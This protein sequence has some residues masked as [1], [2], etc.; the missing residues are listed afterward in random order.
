MQRLLPM[1]STSRT[2]QLRRK[3]PGMSSSSTLAIP[4]CRQRRAHSTK[5]NWRYELSAHP[6]EMLSYRLRLPMGDSWVR[7]GPYQLQ[8]VIR[9]NSVDKGRSGESGQ[10]CTM[11]DKAHISHLIVWSN[12]NIAIKF[13]LKINCSL[14]LFLT[15]SQLFQIRGTGYFIFLGYGETTYFIFQGYGETSCFDVS[16]MLCYLII[17]RFPPTLSWHVGYDWSTVY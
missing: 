16:G 11:L 2:F 17:I 4:P 12:W 3:S 10:C 6:W 9:S 1:A 7:T 13:S 14:H 8:L 5:A 15:I